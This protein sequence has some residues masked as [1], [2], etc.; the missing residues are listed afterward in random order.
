[1][2]ALKTSCINA[3]SP[4]LVW[5]IDER[6]YC[7]ETDSG[8]LFQVTFDLEQSIWLDGAYELGIQNIKHVPSPRDTKLKQTI[9]S[10]VQE[11]FHQNPSIL[12]YIC[13]T[14]D[15]RQA[16]RS[17]LFLHWL[18]E[19]KDLYFIR[20]VRIKSEGMDNFAS[21]IVQQDNPAL[22]QIIEDFELMVHDLTLQKPTNDWDWIEE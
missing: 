12:L 6:R 13:E 16:L 2:N 22:H 19:Y 18:R 10:I 5:S 7:F 17:R 14:G 15:G 21:I 3:T 1:M 11:F 20:S 8:G 9:I 4:Y